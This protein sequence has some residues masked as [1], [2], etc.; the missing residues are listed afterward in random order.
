MHDPA[1]HDGGDDARLL[2]VGRRMTMIKSARWPSAIC[3]RSLSFTA[4]AGV[5]DTNAQACPNG[6]TPCLAS[7]NAASS[8]AG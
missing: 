1:G 3:P 2:P 4:L 8:G 7:A 5:C 6:M